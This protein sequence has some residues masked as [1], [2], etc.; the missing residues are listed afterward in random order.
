M[1]G[2][3]QLARKT[4][5]DTKFLKLYEDTVQLP[6]GQILDDYSL[7]KLPDGVIVVATDESNN[8]LLFKEYK[9]AIDSEV[10][11]FPAG[12]IED[13]EM[14]IE[15][16]TRELLEETGYISDEMELLSTIYDYPSKIQ[17]VD[18]IIRAKNARKAGDVNHEATESIDNVQ[19]VP[20]IE[21]SEYWKRGSFKATY[22]ISALAHAFPEHLLH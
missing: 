7:V 21:L 3:K 19:L 10:M 20:V 4:V 12:G 1:T 13:D 2:W 14:P 17:H 9:Y 15:A 11:T 8:L 22:M 16:A 5:Y 6:S 18:Y